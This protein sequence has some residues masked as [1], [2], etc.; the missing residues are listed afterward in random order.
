MGENYIIFC[1]PIWTEENKSDLINRLKK[2]GILCE[3]L[4]KNLI[5]VKKLRKHH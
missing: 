3:V 4:N 5:N 2:H 1:R